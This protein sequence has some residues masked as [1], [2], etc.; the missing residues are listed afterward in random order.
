MAQFGRVEHLGGELFNKRYTT[1]VLLSPTT[2]G[3]L[4]LDAEQP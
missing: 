4:R 3:I 2:G 1:K